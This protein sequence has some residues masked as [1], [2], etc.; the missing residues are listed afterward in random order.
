MHCKPIYRS[1]RS[2][3]L[4][5]T[6]LVSTTG[7]ASAAPGVSQIVR[8]SVEFA[9]KKSSREVVARASREAVEQSVEA[10]V[11]KFGPRAA[12]AVADG[13]VELV[14]AAVKYGDD[15][16][17]V[18]VEATPAARR[19][20]ALQPSRML[21]LVREF[22]EEAIEIEA[23]SPG[24]ARRVFASFGDD[25]GRQI[26]KQVPAED[27]PRLLTYSEKA[28][29]PETRRILLE[30]Y[31]KEGSSIFEKIPAHLV[32]ATGLSASMLYGTHRRDCSQ[33]RCDRH[34]SPVPGP[35]FSGLTRSHAPV[36]R[37]FRRP[38][39][40]KAT[41]QYTRGYPFFQG[42]FRRL[43]GLLAK[44]MTG[45]RLGNKQLI[46][47][48]LHELLPPLTRDATYERP[49]RDCADETQGLGRVLQRPERKWTMSRFRKRHNRLAHD[50][51]LGLR[52]H[53]KHV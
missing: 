45:L 46:G 17:R 8:E 24:L 43:T 39:C 31:K 51:I 40:R 15:V 5:I 42:P 18:A 10:G 14:E 2:I 36:C 20:L 4:V 1:V 33:G 38:R 26:A 29:T 41:A 44:R 25:G 22:G 47:P 11:V 27:L 35:S 23:K 37:A 13:G 30:V 7:V 12:Q 50:H 28:D 34:R 52:G 3:A 6:A 16:M 21:P 49:R 19:A 32:L 9:F 48:Q 53:E